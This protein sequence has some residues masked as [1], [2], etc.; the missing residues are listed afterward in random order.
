MLVLFDIYIERDLRA[1]KISEK[2]AQELVDHFIIQCRLIRHLRMDAYNQ[3][4]AGDPTWTTEC[5]GWI[6]SIMVSTRSPKLV[7]DFYRV[8]TILGQLQNLI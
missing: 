5:F 1:G 7:L 8:Y 2:E 3:L 4:F 6:F